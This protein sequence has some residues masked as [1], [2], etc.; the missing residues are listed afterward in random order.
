MNTE[1]V[2]AID[3]DQKRETNIFSN[4][5][6]VDARLQHVLE[7]RAARFFSRLKAFSSSSIDYIETTCDLIVN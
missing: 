6:S 4:E 5:K 3:R 1:G 7:E 2:D